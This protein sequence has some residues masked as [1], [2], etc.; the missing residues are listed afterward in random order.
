MFCISQCT[1]A[2][3]SENWAPS[4][5]KVG[6]DGYSCSAI[7]LAVLQLPSNACLPVLSLACL[8]QFQIGHAG[9]LG[10]LGARSTRITKIIYGALLP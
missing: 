6:H 5:Q 8:S 10:L 4:S 2:I 1:T 7:A 3:R 9:I